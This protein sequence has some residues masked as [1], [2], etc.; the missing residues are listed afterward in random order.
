MG[1]NNNNKV[2][3]YWKI[4]L[5]FSEQNVRFLMWVSFFSGVF[6]LMSQNIAAFLGFSS[7]SKYFGLLLVVIF[8]ASTTLLFIDMLYLFGYWLKR[9]D[10]TK[11]FGDDE[12]EILRYFIVKNRKSQ[13]LPM[14]S[15]AMVCLLK[16]D[17]L[18]MA[19]NLTYDYKHAEYTI[20]NW[21]WKYLKKHPHLIDIEKGV[22]ETLPVY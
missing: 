2:K 3:S 10:Y 22:E 15:G 8:L 21:A 4:I 7:F 11:T 12:K 19:T 20:S 14:D 18:R 6:L 16:H 13:T 5:E 17:M 9:R 1:G